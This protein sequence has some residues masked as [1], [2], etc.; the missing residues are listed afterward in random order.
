MP[1]AARPVTRHRARLT[2]QGQITVPKAVRERLGL[3][4]GDD[5]EF[6]PRE[7]GMVVVARPRPSVLDFA[8]LAA[9]A[10]K[11]GRVPADAASLDEAIEQGLGDAVVARVERT[12][13]RAPSAPR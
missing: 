8:G 9:S 5:L 1:A 10:T 2:R 3:R 4:P 6:E 11:A 13:R 7:D 12:G